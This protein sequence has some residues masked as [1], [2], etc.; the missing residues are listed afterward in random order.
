[1]LHITISSFILRDGV[2][3]YVSV[4]IR[5]Q[6]IGHRDSG[7]EV[8][9]SQ[10][11]HGFI[12]LEKWEV[13]ATPTAFSGLFNQDVYRPTAQCRHVYLIQRFPSATKKKE[14][15]IEQNSKSFPFPWVKW[16]NSHNFLY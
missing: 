1:M 5:V 4:R 6:V 15:T 16:L 12:V 8:R 13:G 11:A 9:L 14:K 7:T 2:C 10:E 3:V